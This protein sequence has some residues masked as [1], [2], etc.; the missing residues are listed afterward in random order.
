[1]SDPKQDLAPSGWLNGVNLGIKNKNNPAFQRMNLRNA[2][3]FL[4]VTTTL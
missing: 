3:L 2:G 1:M 4:L